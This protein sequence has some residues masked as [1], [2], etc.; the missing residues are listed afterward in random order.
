MGRDII[1]PYVYDMKRGS[2]S[3][4]RERLPHVLPKAKTQVSNKLHL[5][6][7]LILPLAT[8]D[9]TQRRISTLLKT[10]SHSS[11]R[12]VFWLTTLEFSMI[13]RSLKIHFKMSN[14]CFCIWR[15]VYA[16]IKSVNSGSY[17]LFQ[18]LLLYNQMCQLKTSTFALLFES[19]SEERSACLPGLIHHG[20]VTPNG[21]KGLW[22]YQLRL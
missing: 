16:S 11:M 2:L 7:R 13:W 3:Q 8:P 4:L 18:V 9:T 21:N 6:R 19:S 12:N 15:C 5:Y 10:V 14:I 22:Q 17:R 1:W 20:L